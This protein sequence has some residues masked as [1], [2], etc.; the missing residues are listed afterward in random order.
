MGVIE[1]NQEISALE[2]VQ[3]FGQWK[4]SA[5]KRRNPLGRQN[6]LARGW[7]DPAQKFFEAS[8]VL[9]AELIPFQAAYGRR[10]P[11]T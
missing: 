7:I 2:Q 5:E 10:I 11:D 9:E 4:D 1:Q 8:Q 3:N 6:N